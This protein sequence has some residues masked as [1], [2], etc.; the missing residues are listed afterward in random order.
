MRRFEESDPQE[1]TR[2][3]DMLP[4]DGD[5]LEVALSLIFYF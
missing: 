3:V 5:K 1:A 2:F 4:V